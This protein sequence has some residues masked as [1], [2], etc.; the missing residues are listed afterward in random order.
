MV[1]DSRPAFGCL[2]RQRNC[3]DRLTNKHHIPA[4]P[5]RWT[6]SKCRQMIFTAVVGSSSCAD[7][8]TLA[9]VDNRIALMI[10]YSDK[11]EDE[12]GET[13]KQVEMKSFRANID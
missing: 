12:F 6:H 13:N 3:S 9:I 2:F 10:I 11:R 7:H 4:G 5:L 1:T 8:Q